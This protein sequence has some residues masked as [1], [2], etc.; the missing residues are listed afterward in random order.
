MALRE[1]KPDLTEQFALDKRS[2]VPITDKPKPDPLAAFQPS[3]TTPAPHPPTDTPPPA[4]PAPPS[5]S[6]GKRPS[7]PSTSAS[8]P[9]APAAPKGSSA[10][11]AQGLASLLDDAAVELEEA[12]DIA[13]L[14]ADD[15]IPSLDEADVQTLINAGKDAA[16]TISIG[17]THLANADVS[18]D[19]ALAALR[20][21]DGNEGGANVT[22]LIS[23]A[24]ALQ[25]DLGDAKAQATALDE[26]IKTLLAQMKALDEE[27]SKAQAASSKLRGDVETLATDL[28]NLRV[29]TERAAGEMRAAA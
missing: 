16:G 5:P 21:A 13:A 7:P 15:A 8:A 25:S 27:V 29:E 11:G 28:D 17:L 26:A 12:R 19:G 10:M 18:L 22:A 4:P 23:R 14:T 1:R 2:A 24:S 9:A 3:T 20:G 6:H